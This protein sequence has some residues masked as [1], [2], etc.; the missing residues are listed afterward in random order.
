[1]NDADKEHQQ[2]IIFQA[3]LDMS[4]GPVAIARLM[5]TPY[6]TFRDWKSGKAAMPGAAIRCLEWLVIDYERRKRKSE[7]RARSAATG[8]TR[9]SQE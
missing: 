2:A 6:T 1:M 4:L 7:Q 5:A 9:K 3:E 8:H